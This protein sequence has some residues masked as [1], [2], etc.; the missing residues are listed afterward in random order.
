MIETPAHT[1]LLPR[2]QTLLNDAATAG[3][4][5]DVAVAV[6]TDIIDSPSFN[7]ALPEE[8]QPSHADTH[9]YPHDDQPAPTA[10]IHIPNLLG[11]RRGQ[12]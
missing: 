11:H 1:W 9:I 7:T 12:I 2:L 3:I 4:T 10:N 5:R 6:I 8:P